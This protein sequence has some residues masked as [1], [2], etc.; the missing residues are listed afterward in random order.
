MVAGL[1]VGK[2]CM[3]G[4]GGGAVLCLSEERIGKKK[5]DTQKLQTFLADSSCLQTHIP[6]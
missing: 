5:G 2:Y 3:Y 4:G 6:L 1:R